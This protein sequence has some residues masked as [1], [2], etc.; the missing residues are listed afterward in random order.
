[1]GRFI[2]ID[3]EVSAKFTLI[4]VGKSIERKAGRNRET[5]RQR[6]RER[7]REREGGREGGRNVTR[8][9]ASGGQKV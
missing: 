2:E 8:E 7:E 5:D 3:C 9:R 4:I 6:E 1:V